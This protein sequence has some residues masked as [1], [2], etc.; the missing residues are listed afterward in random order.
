MSIVQ[1]SE[2]VR[3]KAQAA[4]A[5]ARLSGYKLISQARTE[6]ARVAA[7]ALSNNAKAQ[8]TKFQAQTARGHGQSVKAQG[9][10]VA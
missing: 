8:T 10:K 3:R 7:R 1:N 5:T 2:Q 6:K 4:V 9:K